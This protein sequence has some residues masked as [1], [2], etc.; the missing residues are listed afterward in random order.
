M[1]MIANLI[2]K[3]MKIKRYS[4][5]NTKF[6]SHFL[7]YCAILCWYY[8][9]V[10]FLLYMPKYMYYKLTNITIHV[11]KDVCVCVYVHSNYVI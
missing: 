7:Y 9:L 8:I 10:S 2:N 3:L 5:F 11:H 6:T 1:K 4:N